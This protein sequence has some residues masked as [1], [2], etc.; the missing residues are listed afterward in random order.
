LTKHEYLDSTDAELAAL[1]DAWQARQDRRQ[2]WDSWL[3]ANL[4]TLIA[5]SFRSGKGKPITF[6]VDDFMPKRE[7]KPPQTTDQLRFIAEA[8]ASTG[9]GEI[10]QLTPQEKN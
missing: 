7:A 8:F 6:E 3:M 5:N 1:V 10:S 2:R 4:C 9:W